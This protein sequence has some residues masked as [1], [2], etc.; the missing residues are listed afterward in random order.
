MTQV[1]DHASLTQYVIAS[2][3]KGQGREEIE[4]DLQQQG[5]DERFVKDLV[6]EIVR[7]RYAKAR[8]QGLSLILAGAV[9]CGLGFLLTITAAGSVSLPLYGLTSL[10]IILVLGGFTKVF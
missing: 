4:T 5:H 9:V 7:L 2:L 8:A 1:L 10:G 3:H 6:Q